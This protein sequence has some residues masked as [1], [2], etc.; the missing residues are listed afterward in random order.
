MT[1]THK[2]TTGQDTNGLLILTVIQDSDQNVV[3]WVDGL[4]LL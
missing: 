3:I 4:E 2:L 1:G